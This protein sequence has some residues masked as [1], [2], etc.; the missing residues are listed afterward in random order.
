[1]LTLQT[2]VLNCDGTVHACHRAKRPLAQ[3][4]D[5]LC[6]CVYKQAT[7]KHVSATTAASHPFTQFNQQH[8]NSKTIVC[9]NTITSQFKSAQSDHRTNSKPASAHAHVASQ[10]RECILCYACSTHKGLRRGQPNESTGSTQTSAASKSAHLSIWHLPSGHTNL[11]AI[12]KT[13]CDHDACMKQKWLMQ[14]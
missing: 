14:S 4:A 5:K 11:S 1:M 13:R 6:W 12:Q 7:P 3:H 9:T 8:S 2:K 10:F